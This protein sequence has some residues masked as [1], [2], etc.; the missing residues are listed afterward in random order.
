MLLIKFNLHHIGYL[1]YL[2]LRL[3][4]RPTIALLTFDLTYHTSIMQLKMINLTRLF[5]AR[6]LE[7]SRVL[8]T[9]PNLLMKQI[10]HA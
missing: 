3:T 9:L 2:L 6:E 7:A 8:L 4:W 10:H 1:A 5:P